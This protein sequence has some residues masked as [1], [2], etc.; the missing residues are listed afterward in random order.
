MAGTYR[1]QSGFNGLLELLAEFEKAKDYRIIG[2]EKSGKSHKNQAKHQRKNIIP[3]IP[4]T[5]YN[6]CQN[7]MNQTTVTGRQLGCQETIISRK[8]NLSTCPT[9]LE[10]SQLR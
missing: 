10:T 3:R 4:R 7:C 9:K 2:L 5:S 6:N 8:L 1:F